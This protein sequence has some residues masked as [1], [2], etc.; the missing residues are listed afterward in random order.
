MRVATNSS[1]APCEFAT[2]N[3]NSRHLNR[4]ICAA[5]SLYDDTYFD[6]YRYFYFDRITHGRRGHE[7]F[8]F[9]P[10]LLNSASREF[11]AIVASKRQV[12]LQHRVYTD[13]LLPKGR[14]WW[15]TRLLNR[16][17]WL[18]SECELHASFPTFRSGSKQHCILARN[19]N[20]KGH[21]VHALY[22]LV[23]ALWREEF[24]RIW[25][26]FLKRNEGV[27]SE[28]ILEYAET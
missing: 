3:F 11:I 26:G 8:F 27:L 10:E 13:R 19:S 9:V 1:A 22:E 28:L 12:Q 23:F 18:L 20:L 6:Y 17:A 16:F 15:K 2:K 25:A 5:L 24:Y 4:R 14:A 21:V 7:V